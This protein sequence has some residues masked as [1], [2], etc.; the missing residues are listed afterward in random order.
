MPA[1]NGAEYGRTPGFGWNPGSAEYGRTPF[2]RNSGALVWARVGG[3][4]KECRAYSRVG[5]VWKLVTVGA[6]QS[7]TWEP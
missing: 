5:G 7:G 2:I 3:V 1:G 6:R 4:W